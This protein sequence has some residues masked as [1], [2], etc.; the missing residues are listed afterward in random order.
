[1][2]SRYGHLKDDARQDVYLEFLTK[3]KDGKP[4]LYYKKVIRNVVATFLKKEARNSHY[5]FDEQNTN[6]TRNQCTLIYRTQRERSLDNSKVLTEADVFYIKR[7]LLDPNTN[8]TEL[9]NNMNISRTMIYNIDNNLCWNWVEVE[10]DQYELD[11]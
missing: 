6:N 10:S 5:E 11:L 7:K 3:V 4:E 1:M 2:L 8:K 9:A